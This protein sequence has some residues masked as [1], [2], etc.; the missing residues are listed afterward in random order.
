MTREAG[1]GQGTD[2]GMEYVQPW[3]SGEGQTEA[4]PP[5]F[6]WEAPAPTSHQGLESGCPPLWSPQEVW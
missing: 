5:H 4:V 6:S 1:G 3:G 2:G